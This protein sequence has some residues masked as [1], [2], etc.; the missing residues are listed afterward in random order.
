MRMRTHGESETMWMGERAVDRFEFYIQVMRFMSGEKRLEFDGTL[1][2]I[3]DSP[4]GDVAFGD[5]TIKYRDFL[6]AINW[7][8]GQTGSEIKRE[9]MDMEYSHMYA[10]NALFH[11]FLRHNLPTGDFPADAQKIAYFA[12]QLEGAYRGHLPGRFLAEHEP[13]TEDLFGVHVLGTS[14]DLR[15]VWETA[16]DFFA[17]EED[18]QL[19][20]MKI[21]LPDSTEGNV[22]FGAKEIP[23]ADFVDYMCRSCKGNNSLL[24]VYQI[25][26]EVIHDFAMDFLCKELKQRF[27][28]R[29]R[30][31]RVLTWKTQATR[32]N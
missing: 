13:Q 20:G 31:D 30:G 27:P 4:E 19:S 26:Q 25:P 21:V 8:V 9:M 15:L 24:W 22:K 12:R 6:G 23:Y 16:K 28:E 7:A 1:V 14:V 2:M 32:V 18:L 17:G 10:G 29:T 11:K 5:Y 3:P